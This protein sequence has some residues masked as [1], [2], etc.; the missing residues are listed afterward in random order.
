MLDLYHPVLAHDPILCRGLKSPIRNNIEILVAETAVTRG[1]VK[2]ND[3]M[4]KCDPFSRRAHVQPSLGKTHRETP[5][6]DGPKCMITMEQNGKLVW[7]EG[8][9]TNYCLV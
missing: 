9:A 8:I 2:D 4:S 7:H 1:I 6:I 5:G 3:K